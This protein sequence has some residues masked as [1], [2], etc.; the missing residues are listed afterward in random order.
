LFGDPQ[1]S[2]PRRAAFDFALTA[3]PTVEVGGAGGI[4]VHV[5]ENGVAKSGVVVTAYRAA[6]GIVTATTNAQGDAIVPFVALAPGAVSL[7]ARQ[8]GSPTEVASVDAL[9]PTGV[10]GTPDARLTFAVPRPNPSAGD[11]LFRWNVPTDLTDAPSRLV[12]HDIAGRVIR[13]WNLGA[14]A[15]SA[16]NLTWDGRDAT[17]SASPPGLYVARLVVG[18]RA[19]TQLVVRTR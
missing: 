9:A 12:L 18:D 3:P 16:R 7:T 1:L 17:G 4:P 11:V 10:P 5:T 14:G 13:T 8:P 15:A 2:V 6:E 19:L